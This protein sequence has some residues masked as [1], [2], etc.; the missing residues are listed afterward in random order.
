M[1]RVESGC[2]LDAIATG[3]CTRSRSP[4]PRV[5]RSKG[6]EVILLEPDHI[7]IGLL[8]VDAEQVVVDHH[9][10]TVLRW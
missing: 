10:S 8:E 9:R 5:P 3:C 4:S 7:V 6:L 2:P 1:S